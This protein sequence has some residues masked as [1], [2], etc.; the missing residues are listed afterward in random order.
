MW[1]IINLPVLLIIIVIL[2]LAAMFTLLEYSIIK[3]RP[4]ELEEMDQTQKIKRARHMVANLTEYLS[5]AQV[6]IT[7]TSLILGWIGEEYITNLI[8][9]TNLLHHQEV[10]F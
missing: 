6:G 5:T 7:L 1:E 9:A 4:S 2:L 8:E 3:V 10:Q